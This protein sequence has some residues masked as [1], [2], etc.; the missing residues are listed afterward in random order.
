[1]IQLKEIP[2]SF[3]AKSHTYTNTETGE[4]LQGIT[5]TLLRR[6]FPDKYA[7]IP[8]HILEAAAARGT[9]VHNEIEIAEE[10]DTEFTTHQGE[11]YRMMKEREGL[12]FLTSE[13]CVS[14][15]E[16]YAS[17][18]DLVFEGESGVYLA[19]IKTTQKFDAESVSWQLSI[20]AYLFGLANPD[21][22]VERLYGI[23]VRE[24][25]AEL[26]EVRRHTADEVEALIAADLQ[27]I[28][29]GRPDD[30]PKYIAAVTPLLRSLKERIDALTAEYD[31]IKNN[32][33]M[34]MQEHG[35]KTAECDGLKVTYTP[36]TERRSFDSKAFQKDNKDLYDKYTK[37]T[38]TSPQIRITIKKQD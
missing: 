15:L 12:K 31:T 36:P 4:I 17:K 19:D 22:K 7:G 30:T 34:Q 23:W 10:L 32:L 27:D 20:Y 33:M 24:E 35:D 37:L 3:D 9:A 25:F 28:P 18:I 13:Y 26:I 5:Q 14:D 16:H 21:I 11:N 29:F 2:V 8:Q 1:M 6:I 38:S